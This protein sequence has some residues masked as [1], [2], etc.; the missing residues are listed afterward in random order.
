MR[1]GLD[2]LVG[3]TILTETDGVV[4]SDPDNTD[5]GNRA[6]P[7][8][9]SSIR[10]KVQEGAAKRNDVTVGSKT[11]HDGTHGMLTDTITDVASSIVT[12]SG[13]LWLEVGGSLST[14]QV[15]TGQIGR[16]TNEL[17]NDTIELLEHCLGELARS[18]S[19][20]GGLVG[21]KN[22]LPA[23]GKLASKSSLQVGALRGKLLLVRFEKLVPFGFSAGTSG[24]NLSIRIIDLLGN[25]ERFLRVEAKLLL[26]SLG[27]VGLERRSVNPTSSLKLGA[28]SD[29]GGELDH[30]RLVL[31][32]LGCRDGFLHG[33]QIGVTLLHG[34]R[35]PAVG[36]KSLRDVLGEGTSS[37]TILRDELVPVWSKKEDELSYDRDMI[38]IVD[39]NQIAQLQVTSS[40]SSLRGDALHSTSIAEE[41]ICVVVEQVISGLVEVG[42]AVSLSHGK[43]HSIGEA[44]TQ[45]TGCH[46]DTRGI[47]LAN[48]LV[49]PSMCGRR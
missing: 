30:C 23:L 9:T 38:V 31:D 4:G 6:Q 2:R 17:G 27:I 20:V 33:I 25:I 45:R 29:G 43:A 28:K 16:T 21:G 10:Y 1:K 3:R 49:L 34:Q 36:F 14:S 48:Y 19:R 47:M 12:K 32:C 13:G 26:H 7:D 5:L 44:L 11:V 40:G 22:L 46:L 15:G 42:G 37:I 18:N 24:G 39:C 35:V 8:G 41:D